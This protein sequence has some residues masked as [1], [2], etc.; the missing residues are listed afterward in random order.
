FMD[1]LYEDNHLIAVFKP[2]GKLVQGDHSGDPCLLDEV[3]YFIK[4]R[5]NKPGNVFLGMLHRL[6]RPVSGIVLFAKTSK[7]ASRLSEQFRNHTIEKTYHA[8]IIGVPKEK[9]A[10]L[11]HYLK[12]DPNVNKTQVFDRPVDGAQEA[13][14]A[15]EVVTPAS[16]PPHGGRNTLVK[17]NLETGRPH[18]IRAQLA[19][20][21]HPIVGDVKYGAP[22]QSADR[23][24][25]LCATGLR[26]RLSTKDEEKEI[27]I[28][29]PADWRKYIS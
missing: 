16:L 8:L 13:V 11:V 7:G 24:L 14:L 23:S 21:G 26:F 12:K 20:I 27:T 2:A 19:A 17:I 15:Y 4:Q 5:D 18:Q 3:K 29:V 10:R 28:S 1:I 25:A 9:S 6:D 22:I